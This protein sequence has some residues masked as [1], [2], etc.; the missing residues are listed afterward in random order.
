M[1]EGGFT[2][3]VAGSMD[4]AESVGD[5]AG[6]ID[7]N[8]QPAGLRIPAQYLPK[9]VGDAQAK[10]FL[11]ILWNN[12]L[13]GGDPDFDYLVDYI[14]DYP[15]FSESEKSREL[16]SI[17]LDAAEALAEFLIAQ[18]IAQQE[19]FG[20]VPPMPITLAFAELERNRIIARENFACCQTCGHDEILGQVAAPS[21]W[22]AYVFFHQQDAEA[23]F[24]CGAG[25]LAFGLA[26]GGRTAGLNMSDLI[27]STI[28]P[29]LEKHG[30]N[31][32]WDGDE[33]TRILLENVNLYYPLEWLSPHP[34]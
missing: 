24:E 32:K 28:L 21:Q 7:Y 19:T 16:D 31:A 5:G 22:N 8:A 11:D 26:P 23:I 18:R 4:A 9:G 27:R 3:D 2:V 17:P 6:P 13:M 20:Q 25:A 29:T 12:L 34:S 14:C 30:V 15:F 10:E 33:R 1:S